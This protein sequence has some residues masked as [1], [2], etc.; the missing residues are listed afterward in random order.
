MKAYR[1]NYERFRVNAI[2]SLTGRI[3]GGYEKRSV[4]IKDLSS[5]GAGIISYS[6]LEAMNKVTLDFEIPPLFS[7]P[8]RKE[9][10]I[11]WSKPE[12]DHWIC[13]LN[14]GINSLAF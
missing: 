7:Q 5:R 3:A 8:V 12:S 13:G 10:V 4:I 14:F 6:P 11:A 2:A 9:A 1:R